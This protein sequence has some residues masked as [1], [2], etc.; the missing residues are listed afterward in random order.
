VATLAKDPTGWELEDFIAAHFVSRGCYVETGV[1]E[2]NPDELLELDIVWTDY[3]REPPIP[4][5]V[6]V[7]SGDWGLGD[8]F[9]FFGW[10]SYLHLEPG[11][12]VHKEPCGRL[13]PGTL[14]HVRKGTAIT[15]L[16]LSKPEDGEA[17]F[18]TLG[19][20]D[21]P[22]PE[23]PELWRYS[24][25]AQR[26]LLRSLNEAIRQGIA[27]E[28]AK[29]AKE[30]HLLINDAVFFVPDVRDR[31]GD[32]L[33]AHFDHQKLGRSAAYEIEKG[34]LDFDEPPKT[35][36]FELAY[37]YG[38]HFPVQA[39]L[40]LAHRARLYI[41]KAVVDY[42]LA[43]ERGEIQKKTLKIGDALLDLTGGR[44][45][46][47]MASGVE[48]LSAARSF[49]LFPTF[50]QVFLWSWGGFLLKDRLA[51]EYDALSRETGVP[52]EELPL[53]LSAFDHLFPTPGGWFREPD[54]DSRRV[55]VLMP[56]AMRGLGAYR[57]RLRGGVE[58]Y[59]ELGYADSTAS[60][61]ACD[62]NAG[63]RLLDCKDADL[64]K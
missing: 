56:A 33:S 29:A 13:D 16:H 48:T 21:P 26:R 50:W 2:R 42:W 43:R 44:L 17:H 23:L 31:V 22:S 41:L 7:K 5:P 63:A 25:W 49:R 57:R 46:A 36:T 6:E 24:F 53:A 47:A 15:L 38:K 1:K 14:A 55:L 45:T 3:R 39:S 51:E 52:V 20:P 62:H 11:E 9:K 40:Y 58:H 35:R 19:L 10:T 28:S 27:A 60:R 8:V 12:F 64:V 34:T 37:Y 61:M 30:Y 4:H 18:R 59:H 54:N 32:L